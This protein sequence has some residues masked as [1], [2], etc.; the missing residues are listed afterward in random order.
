MIKRKGLFGIASSLT[1]NGD[2][3][4]PMRKV[5]KVA[6]Q[7]ANVLVKGCFQIG[8]FD[9]AGTG[10]AADN[11]VGWNASVL[12][13]NLRHSVIFGKS[14]QADFEALRDFISSQVERIANLPSHES[15]N[16]LGKAD[17]L[18][19]FAELKAVGL[20]QEEFEIEKK[21]LLN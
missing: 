21:K 7:N 6:L 13:G 14:A 18:K 8:V 20:S 15:G 16:F 3:A 19:K 11:V 9:K 10:V 2:E 1:G 4:I 5:G 12:A 17:E